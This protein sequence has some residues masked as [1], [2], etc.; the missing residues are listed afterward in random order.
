VI[1]F[2]YGSDFHFPEIGSFNESQNQFFLN[3]NNWQLLSSGRDACF[4]LLENIPEWKKLW[5]PIYYCEDVVLKLQHRFTNKIR[6]YNDS[7]EVFDDSPFSS[8]FTE[9]DV[10]VRTNYFGIRQPS[11]WKKLGVIQIFDLTHD[12]GQLFSGRTNS[13]DFV[14]ASLRKTIPI[15]DGGI[16][17]IVPQARFLPQQNIAHEQS[18]NQ[19]AT[20]MALKS[21]YLQ[22]AILDKS[23][24]RNMFL[25]SEA[26]F[27]TIYLA[28]LSNISESILPFINFK[29]LY[30][31]KAENHKL[32]QEGLPPHVFYKSLGSFTSAFSAMLKFES[33]E[34]RD[35][36]RFYLIQKGIYPAVYW[37]FSESYKEQH[38]AQ[39]LHF[40]E[41]CLSIPIDY[42]YG[43]IE[44][45]QIIQVLNEVIC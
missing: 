34:Q 29:R 15:P 27:G 44:V 42:R 38:G 5:L 37:P 6:F 8:L 10:V 17:S 2:E 9:G 4:Y 11:Y 40:S 13:A 16:A 18:S 39:N 28:K 30:Q 33:K 31:L 1:R 3:V 41:I 23:F 20:A 45:K 19:R 32:F 7:P 36:V 14:F 43:E 26:H 25:E 12:L 35:S 21:A 24:W 22:G